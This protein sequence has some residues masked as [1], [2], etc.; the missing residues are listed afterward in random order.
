MEEKKKTYF[1]GGKECSLV[2][3][4]G[5]AYRDIKMMTLK[6]P[7]LPPQDKASIIK[8]FKLAS[9]ADDDEVKKILADTVP[10]TQYYEDMTE[11]LFL[12]KPKLNFENINLAEVNRALNDFF[13]ALEGN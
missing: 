9:G 6:H 7:A 1:P 3:C 10:V 4:T 8:E 13:T 12:E 11:I 5:K 2:P